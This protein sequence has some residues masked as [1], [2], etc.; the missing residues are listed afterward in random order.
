MSARHSGHAVAAVLGILLCLAAPIDASAQEGTAKSYDFGSLVEKQAAPKQPSVPPPGLCTD[1]AD[2]ARQACARWQKAAYDHQ[3]WM[4]KY[5]EKAFDAHHFY[6]IIVFA[7]VCGMV[8]LGMYLSYKEF[9]IGAS[10]RQKLIERLVQRMRR[11]AG[12]KPDDAKAA[13]DQDL[14]VEEK[15]AAA[16]ALEIGTSGVKLTSQVLGVIV[17]VVSMGFFYLYL[18]T[19]YPIQESNVPSA[20]AATSA[21]A[22]AAEPK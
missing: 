8:L 9:A 12:D 18:K 14:S 17:L 5:R 1:L 4:L 2:E 15:A 21:P 11:P 6:T 7:I 22:A 13:G 19:V 20:A 3:A 10:R 16:T